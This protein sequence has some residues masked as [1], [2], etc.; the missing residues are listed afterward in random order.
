MSQSD[1]QYQLSTL[2]HLEYLFKKQLGLYLLLAKSNELTFK[3]YIELEPIYQDILLH[4]KINQKTANHINYNYN[5][6]IDNK[7]LSFI[8]FYYYFL[9]TYQEHIDEEEHPNFIETII[10][11]RLFDEIK[12]NPQISSE[13]HQLKTYDSRHSNK[14]KE[15]EGKTLRKIMLKGKTL[16]LDITREIY[17]LSKQTID[18]FKHILDSYEKPFNIYI[19]LD[20][21]LDPKQRKY[22]FELYYKRLICD[23]LYEVYKGYQ[24]KPLSFDW[25]R[26]RKLL[27]HYEQ[28]HFSNAIPYSIN[29]CFGDYLPFFFMNDKILFKKYLKAITQPT[30]RPPQIYTPYYI[31]NPNKFSFINL[32]KDVKRYLLEMPYGS[33]KQINSMTRF[34]KHYATGILEKQ[35][36]YK[37]ILKTIKNYPRVF[38]HSDTFGVISLESPSQK[39]LEGNRITLRFFIYNL[40]TEKISEG[41]FHYYRSFKMDK[42]KDKFFSILKQGTA[43]F[44]KLFNFYPFHP[45]FFNRMNYH[46]VLYSAKIFAIDTIHPNFKLG[47]DVDPLLDDLFFQMEYPDTIDLDLISTSLDSI[48][49]KLL[50]KIS[51]SFFND[52]A[53]LWVLTYIEK[54]FYLLALLENKLPKIERNFEIIR[55]TFFSFINEIEDKLKAEVKDLEEF[56]LIIQLPKIADNLID[57]IYFPRTLGLYYCLNYNKDARRLRIFKLN[58]ISFNGIELYIIKKEFK[59]DPKLKLL[60][61]RQTQQQDNLMKELFIENL[62]N[63]QFIK[64]K[65]LFS[66]LYPEFIRLHSLDLLVDEVNNY[67]GLIL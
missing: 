63:E 8:E 14:F 10:I 47:Y 22:I 40:S 36:V 55:D 35:E 66:D 29:L 52:S 19:N 28:F 53:Y 46:M 64:I 42:E 7:S 48:K 26:Y 43:I 30:V 24:Q 57:D 20:K 17:D 67:E 11:P 21:F 59:K 15:F 5:F 56:K 60:K 44:E 12:K 54:Y 4:C 58:S 18:L 16:K 1:S 45:F 6:I 25:R 32:N 34:Y 27:L 39:S 49:N 33:K 13:I 50:R 38:F 2:N 3:I 65:K 31:S 41:L 23:D 61:I 51:I 9:S 62:S 37:K